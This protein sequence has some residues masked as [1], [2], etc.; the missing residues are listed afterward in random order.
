MKRWPVIRHIRYWLASY[1]VH[2]WA[3]L[4][5]QGGVGLGWPNPSDLAHL[6]RIWTG[7]E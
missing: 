4:W 1:R 7:R 2:R 5:G 6:D 3:Q